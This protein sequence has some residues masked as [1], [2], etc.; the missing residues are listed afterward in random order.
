MDADSENLS[1]K[2]SFNLA[3]ESWKLDPKCHRVTHD[4]WNIYA[5]SL[6]EFYQIHFF[7]GKNFFFVQLLMNQGHL[8]AYLLG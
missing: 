3:L 6:I 8:V 4:S 1:T 5:A 2:Q 7:Q